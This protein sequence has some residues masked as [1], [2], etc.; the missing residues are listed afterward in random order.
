[1]P[2]DLVNAA[3]YGFEGDYWNAGLSG[4]A[5][6]PVLGYGANAWK[7]ARYADEFVDVG[8][9]FGGGYSGR[10]AEFWR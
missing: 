6:I 9:H 4:M 8:R 7:G 1:M 5:A 10:R 2:F 3:V